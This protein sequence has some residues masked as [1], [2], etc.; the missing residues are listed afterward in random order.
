MSTGMSNIESVCVSVLGIV[1]ESKPVR[2][3]GSGSTIDMGLGGAGFV[4]NAGR[5]GRVGGE[6]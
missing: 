5:V 3:S 4:S 1:S 2:V 6:K